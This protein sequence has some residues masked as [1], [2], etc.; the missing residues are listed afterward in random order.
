MFDMRVVS[1]TEECFDEPPC[2]YTT[3]EE[4]EEEGWD[5]HTRC[6][7]SSGTWYTEPHMISFYETYLQ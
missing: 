3:Q 7:Y 6:K 5:R 1:V 4:E 2:A